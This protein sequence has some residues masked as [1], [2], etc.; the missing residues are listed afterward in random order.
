MLLSHLCE[1]SLIALIT[2]LLSDV[3]NQIYTDF[4][5]NLFVEVK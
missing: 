5:E 4:Q 1:Q 2:I 3:F